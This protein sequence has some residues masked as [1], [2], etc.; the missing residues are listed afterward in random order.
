MLKVLM[1]FDD[2]SARSL[3]RDLLR[4]LDEERTA[5]GARGGFP[6]EASRIVQED[7]VSVVRQNL[8]ESKAE[9]DKGRAAARDLVFTYRD[10]KTGRI[11]EKTYSGGDF[12]YLA[13]TLT[14]PPFPEPREHQHVPPQM[15]Q[16]ELR[17][18]ARGFFIGVGNIPEMDR[19]TMVRSRGGKEVPLWRVL[20]KGAKPSAPYAAIHRG[21]SGRPGWIAVYD[22]GQ[23]FF[24][25][26]GRTMRGNPGR[27]G[28]NFFA[29]AAMAVQHGQLRVIPRIHEA[30]YQAIRRVWKSSTAV[31][32]PRMRMRLVAGARRRG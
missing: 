29:R 2:T 10:R 7:F 30:A 20:E 24:R 19:R 18:T 21:P 22:F 14:H 25:L 27:E 1:A 31:R 28:R 13:R 16:R 4:A 23:G 11:Q 3:A 6:T 8:E 9:T 17:K 12:G 26:V 32:R 15:I 5:T